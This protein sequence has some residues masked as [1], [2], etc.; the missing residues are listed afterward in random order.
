M[1]ARFQ[2]Q[3]RGRRD[4][5]GTSPRSPP[6][7]SVAGEAPVTAAVGCEPRRSSGS[8]R[9]RSRSRPRLRSSSSTSR[10]T[11]GIWPAD[12]RVRH[13]LS[14]TSGYDCEL[15]GDLARFGDGRRRAGGR[16]RR[17]ARSVRRFLGVEQAWSYANTGYWLAGHLAAER[18]DARTRT[19]WPAAHPR[20]R[21]A[22]SRRRS[23]SPS[24]PAPAERPWT[25]RTRAPAGRP[26]GSCLERRPTCCASARRHLGRAQDR[27]GCASPQGQ[28][29]AGVYGLGLFGERVGGVEVWGHGGSLRRVPVL[30]PASCPTA[31]RCSPA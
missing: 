8:R 4:S 19:R 30:A 1:N 13:L 12:V 31:R 23:A 18:P 26:A 24:S 22:S 17:A 21:R 28:P 16:R 29:T 20:A 10:P 25:F 14:H 11:T 6:G 15:P 9:S 27:R 2:S 3:A 5:R 7:I